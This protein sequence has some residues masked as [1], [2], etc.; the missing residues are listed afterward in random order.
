[1]EAGHSPAS[2]SS[3]AP[4]WTWLVVIGIGVL[5]LVSNAIG[6]A[7]V[8]LL[9]AIL[10]AVMVRD[11]SSPLVVGAAAAGITAGAIWRI[12]RVLKIGSLSSAVA[13]AAGWVLSLGAFT[14]MAAGA[15]NMMLTAMLVSGAIWMVGS[16]IHTGIG[17]LGIRAK[18]RAARQDDSEPQ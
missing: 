11:P 2:P 4:A 3:R 14:L 18:A 9:L 13:A 8:G 10:S 5:S 16:A 7:F 6:G 15:E 12:G 1:M 17:I